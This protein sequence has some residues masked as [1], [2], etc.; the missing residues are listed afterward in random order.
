MIDLLLN[1][2]FYTLIVGTLFGF[3]RLGK[4]PT[5]VDRILAF[6]AVVICSVGLVVLLSRIWETPLYLELI[7]IISSLGFFSTVALV[8]YLQ[9][10]MPA[11]SG[12]NAAD[13]EVE[14]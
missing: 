4:G 12:D 3:Y 7:L 14:Q 11:R 13:P 10:T 6:D 5:V 8:T 2:A 9:R 1:V